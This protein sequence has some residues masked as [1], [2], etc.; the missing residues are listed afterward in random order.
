[1]RLVF[2]LETNGLPRKGLD[3]IHCI[4]TK[5]IDSGQVCRY[6]DHGETEYRC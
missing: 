5:D 6:S 4:V 3:T 1:M 2:D